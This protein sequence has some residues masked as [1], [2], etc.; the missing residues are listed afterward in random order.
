VDDANIET[1]GYGGQLSSS[2]EWISDSIELPVFKVQCEISFG[3]KFRV[4][5]IDACS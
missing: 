3:T 2:S 4:E 1:H 5:M